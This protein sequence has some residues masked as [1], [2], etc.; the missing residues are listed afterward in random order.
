MA[1]LGENPCSPYR[2]PFG[3]INRAQHFSLDASPLRCAARAAQVYLHLIPGSHGDKMMAMFAGSRMLQVN[4]ELNR[5]SFPLWVLYPTRTPSAPVA[6]GPYVSD[7]SVDAPL[8]PGVFPLVAISHGSKGSPF[9]YRTLAA[10]L[11][12]NGYIVALPEHPHDN[13]NNSDGFGTLDNLV[14]RPRHIRL[15]IDALVNDPIFK[16]GL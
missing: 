8:E 11:A 7:V 9:L 1:S 16:N 12:K 5:L 4:D 14:N 13:R 2:K 6:F 10:H 15:A 3:G